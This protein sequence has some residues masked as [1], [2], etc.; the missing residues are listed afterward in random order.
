MTTAVITKIKNDSVPLPKGWRGSRVLV[1]VTG[2]TATITKVP[3][4]KT[5]FTDGDIRALRM[6]G[7]NVSKQTLA[8]AL[9]AARG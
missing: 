1:R 6:L 4:S 3:K 5:I 9:R 7:A 2:N 8:K